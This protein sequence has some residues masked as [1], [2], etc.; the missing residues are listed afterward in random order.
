MKRLLF[1][2]VK[3]TS[4]SQMAEALAKK[5]LPGVEA[6]SAGIH[7]G[8]KVNPV[9]VEAMR[10]VG[11]DISGHRAKHV[12]AF[13]A[14]TFD[15]VYKMDSPDLSDYVKAKWMENW[16]VPD[17]AQGEI[18]QFRHVREMLIARIEGLRA[19]WQPLGGGMKVAHS[20]H[21]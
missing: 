11:L 21:G 12:S 16:E 8:E 20:G 13:S 4:R 18:E 10:E 9:A 5:L 1:V 3:N 19:Q 14:L 6:Y 7:P 2:C 17:P 15:A